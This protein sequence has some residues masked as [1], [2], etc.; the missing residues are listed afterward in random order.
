M[1]RN[2]CSDF[3]CPKGKHTICKP[4]RNRRWKLPFETCGI[5][6]NLIQKK[7]VAMGRPTWV[8]HHP[9]QRNKQN[10]PFHL[11]IRNRSTWRAGKSWHKSQHEWIAATIKYVFY[12]RCFARTIYETTHRVCTEWTKLSFSF[13]PRSRSYFTGLAPTKKDVMIVSCFSLLF[14]NN[15]PR[16]CYCCC[17]G[18]FHLQLVL[19]L[20]ACV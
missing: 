1:K 10:L 7:N 5:K 12:L 11:N 9:Q 8:P 19:L 18:C 17:S 2:R 4:M 6:K 15:F 14:S 20:C 16:H 3:Q 13:T